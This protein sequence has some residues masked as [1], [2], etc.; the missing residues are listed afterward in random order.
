[1]RIIDLQMVGAD[2]TWRLEWTT[3]PG[4][5]YQV[6]RSS[7][8]YLP[9]RGSDWLPLTTIRAAGAITGANDLVGAT[10]DQRYYRVVELAPSAIDTQP[11]TI[12]YGGVEPAALP[13]GA[14][15]LRVRFQATDN[16]G[17][18][19]V[20]VRE[21]G[22]VL[23]HATPVGG[24]DWVLIVPARVTSFASRLF[25]ATATDPSG[26]TADSNT[27]G[28]ILA[29]P[30]YFIP[31]ETNGVP[32]EGRF[33]SVIETNRV[34]P[35]VF[36]PG[37]RPRA[38]EAPDLF[39]RFPEGGTIETNGPAS[40]IHFQRVSA[41]FEPGS[42]FRLASALERND[43][44]DKTLRVGAFG[45]SDLAALFQVSATNGVGLVLFD[46]FPI[47][48][49]GGTID[50]RGWVGAQF[51]SEIP[52]LPLSG[53]S[54]ALPGMLTEFARERTLRIP[55]SG[56]IPLGGAISGA[57]KMQVNA[58][59]PLWLSLRADGQASLAG[60]V[61]L[62][63]PNGQN[64]QA[65]LRLDDPNYCLALAASGLR[66]QAA[67]NLVDLLPGN[68]G[69]C[70]PANATA[71]QLA[72]A[73]SCLNSF[74]RAYAN[75]TA[76]VASSASNAP[77]SAAEPPSGVNAFSSALEAWGFSAL[78]G[79]IQ[80]LPL[81]AIV[82][83]ANQS[84]NQAGSA[85]ELPEVL[86]NRLALMRARAA[87]QAGGLNGSAAARAQLDQAL[88]QAE[89]AAIDRAQNP[90]A[91]LSLASMKQAA[92]LLVETEAA[93]QLAGL[94]PGGLLAALPNLFVRF[95]DQLADRFGVRTN[96]FTSVANPAINTMN[97]FIAIELLRDIIDVQ[98]SAQL[99]GVN[100][101][102]TRLDELTAQLGLRLLE[103]VNQ[104]LN[105]AEA[106]ADFP[107]FMLAAQDLM[108]L[109]SW[110]QLG[111]FPSVPELNALGSLS[112][113]NA[114]ASRINNLGQFELERPL[115]DKT[116]GRQAQEIRALLK[117]MRQ[118][119]SSV[120]FGAPP[121]RRACDQL[122]TQLT[123]IVNAAGLASFTNTL[124]LLELLEAGLL[125][126][127]LGARFS[128]PQPVSWE[129]TRLPLI[130]ARISQ[131][132]T[133]QLAWRELD[134]AIRL[135][136]AAADR[137]GTS[138]DQ[139]LRRAYLLQTASVITTTRTVAQNLLRGASGSVRLL[140]MAMPGDL[141]IDNPAGYACYN[142]LS[143][144]FFG[145]VRG[146]LRIP[147]M[148][149]SLTVPNASFDNRGGFDLTAFGLVNFN[150]G[151]F[152][153]PARQP[154]HIWNRQERGLAMEGGARLSLSNGMRFDASVSL[155]DPRYSFALSARGLE[156]DLGRQLILQR[157]TL[158]AAALNN[159]GASTR[160]ALADYLRELN[161]G[162]ET[163][164]NAAVGFPPI[165]ESG[166]GKPPEFSSPEIPFDF[167]TLNAW[168]AGI[169]A[170]TRAGLSNVAQS[171]N[172]VLAS[173]QRLN[174][175]AR[176]ATNAL[177]D[178][179]GKLA[180]LARRMEL[181]RKMKEASNLAAQQ[182]LA[183]GP[184]LGQLDAA[185]L[186]GARQELTN[187]LVLLT[188]D[189][190]NRLADSLDLV[191]IMYGTESTL[192]SLNA[193]TGSDLPL[194][195]D[196]CTN[197][198][199]GTASLFQRAEALALCT[200]RRQ[201]LNFGLNPTTGSVADTNRFQSFS[202]QE[203]DQATALMLR[204]E[205]V[206][207]TQGGDD[208]GAMLDLVAPLIARQRTLQLLEL[209]NNPSITP[210]RSIE[211]QMLLLNNAAAL[212]SA[213]IDDDGFSDLVSA[214]ESNLATLLSNTPPA[215][216]DRAK[217]EASLAIARRNRQI[218]SD[219]DHALGTD[220]RV[221]V[222]GSD[223]DYQPDFLT[224]LNHFFLVAQRPVPDSIKNNMDAY[225]RFKAQELRARPFTPDFL[226]NRL[227]EIKGLA[228][229]V[230]GLTDWAGFRMTN[231]FA[232]LTN[233]QLNLSNFTFSV[234]QVA[235]AQKAWWIL[236]RYEN[237]L[238]IHT[239]IYGSNLVASLNGSLAQAQSA[240]IAAA[241]RI[242]D[243]LVSLV[244]AI[245]FEDVIVPL[246]GG[247][248]IERISG[249]LRFNRQ[250]GFLEG[251]FGG[252]VRFSDVNTNLFFEI[253]EACLANT[254]A[255]S[256]D[257]QMGTP[258]PFGQARLLAGL[259]IAGSPAG[260]A[261]FAGDGT[262]TLPN[263][264][265]GD[266]TF[267]VSLRYDQAQRRLG[268]DALGS[269]LDLRLAE[270]FVLFDAGVGFE[271]TTGAPQ[272]SF[273]VSGSAG[274]FAKQ[275][276]LPAVIS[277]ASFHLSV[278]NLTTA[279]S[280]NT[281]AFALSL[282]NGVI[283]LPDIFH[284]GIC[285]TN[286]G[287][288]ATG[289]QLALVAANPLTV[290]VE[291]STKASFS[292][293]LDFRNLGFN[294]PGLTNLGIEVCSTRLAFRSNALPLLQDF[295]AT[296]ALPLPG[297]TSIVDVTGVDWA[298]D[299]FPTAG[300]IALRNGLRLL[301]LGGFT[302]DFITNSSFGIERTG[303][304]TI[305]NLAGGIKGTFPAN[306]LADAQNNAAFSFGTAGTFHWETGQEPALSLDQV[307]FGG[308]LKLGGP[309][310]FTLTGVDA[311]GIPNLTDTNSLASIT[312][313]GLPNIL[314]LAT[315]A[316][317]EISVN[318]ALGAAEFI[319]FGLKDAKFVFDGV[320][321]STNP[322][323]RFQVTALGFRE[324]E[325]LKMLGQENLPLRITEGSVEFLNPG[326]PLNQL[327]NPTNLRFTISGE[328]NVAL[329][330]PDA[331]EPQ[332]PRLSGAVNRA[333]ITLPNG[334]AGAPQFSVNG[335]FL[336]LENLKIGDM[337][338]LSGGLAVGNLNSPSE[339]FF[340]G[341]VG[342]EYNGA[343]IKA[344]VAA[345]TTGL[346]GLCLA[347]NAGPAGI[348]LDG[349][350]LGG[351][352]LTGAEGG[353][354]FLNQFADPCDFQ[355]FLELSSDGRPPSP[356]SGALRAASFIGPRVSDLAVLSWAELHELQQLHEKRKS[357]ESTLGRQGLM[358]ALS[359][360]VP[361]PTGD[362][363]PA[364]INLLCQRHPS[365]AENPAP[366]NY[367]GE[368][369]QRVIFK[370][371]SLG[372]DTVDDILALAN[373]NLQGSA[374]VIAVNF[375]NGVRD[376]VNTLIPRPPS[377]LGT[378]QAI[379]NDFIDR[380]LDAMRGAIIT[381]VSTALSKVPAN[382]SRLEAIYK[383]AYAGVSCVDITIQLKG[384]FS[385]A[386]VS[387]ALSAVGG[388]VASTTGSAGITG[389]VN[390][391][392]VPVGTGEFFY[393]ITDTNGNPNPSFC[394]NMHVAL[395]PLQFG[396]MGIKLDCPSC[397]TG[398]IQ[399]MGTF[400]GGLSSDVFAESSLL[401]RHFV[402]NAA[403]I[404]FANADVRTLFGVGA[405][406]LAP[407]QQ[408]AV[409]TSL[410]NLPEI[411]RFLQSTPGAVNEFG[412]NA[413]NALGART[414]QLI[415]DLYN[416]VNPTFQ[417][418]GEVQPKIFGFS[419][420]GGNSLV[421]ARMFADKTNARGDLAFSPSYILGNLPFFILS[422][423]SINNI[424]PALDQAEM[425]FSFGLPILSADL[426]HLLS[427][428]PAAF[429][430]S[431]LD[432]MM[433]NSTLT[434]GYKL[435]PFGFKLADGQG[436]IIV[437]TL[438]H[439][440]LNPARGEFVQPTAPDRGAVLK[441][442]LDANQLS[443]ATWAGR[444]P[445]LAALFAAGSTEAR[446]AANRE[447]L[448]D[449]FP[450]GGFVGA[451]KV[452]FPRPL[453]DAPPLSD[454]GQLFAPFEPSQ[455]E[456]RLRLAERIFTNYVMGSRQI[457]D[458]A[459][460]VPFPNPP[461]AV[462]TAALGP[463]AFINA[464][465][466][467]D[468]DALIA[469]GGLDL[470]PV[471]QFFMLGNVDVQLIGLPLGRGELI[472]DPGLGLFRL[473]AGIPSDSWLHQFVQGSLTGEIR[474]AEYILKTNPGQLPPG[475]SASDLEPE[476]R[477]NIV[478]N[479][480]KQAFAPGT[481][482]AQ[483]QAAINDAITRITDT[484]PKASVSAQLNL[485]VPTNLT[486]FLKFKQG[487]G[488]FAFSP[489]FDP[490]YA[491]PGS[492]NPV[493]FPDPD[494]NNPGPYTLARR[495]GGMAAVG[496]FEFGFN[497]TDPNTNRHLIVSIPEMALGIAGSS[498]SN[499]F[500]A[501]NG[502]VRVDNVTLPSAFTFNN[503][504]TPPFQFRDGLMQFNS[505]P[506]INAD[507]LNIAGGMT[508][509]DLGPFL[510]VRPLPA[511]ANPA[512]LL[513]GNLRVTRTSIGSSMS[514]SINAAEATI[515]IL[516]NNLRGT[517]FGEEKEPGRFTP[518]TFSTV[519]GQAWAASMK[520]DGAVEIR[521]PLDPTGPVFFRAEALRVNNS[522]VP[523]LAQIDGVGL[524]RF[525]LR[526]TIPNGLQ[527]TLFPGT[528]QQSIY[529]TGDNSATCLFVSSD[530]RIY[531][532]S[533]TRTLDLN[534]LANVEGRIEFGFE[535][536]NR[537][538][539]ISR[540]VV[541]N[542]VT[543]L[544]H[545]VT[546]TLA[547]SNTN[548][549]GSQLQ[550]DASITDSSNFSIVPHRLILGPKQ[551]ANIQVRFTPRTAGT[552]RPQL[553]LSNNSAAPVLNVSMTGIVTTLPKMHVQLASIDFG[554][555]PLGETRGQ[556]VRISNLGDTALTVSNIVTT[557][558]RFTDNASFLTVPA[559]SF[560][561]I[562]VSFTPTVTTATN[563]LLTFNSNDPS[564]SSAQVSLLGSG[565]NRFWYRQ[566]HGFGFEHLFDIEAKTD[567]TLAALGHSGTFWQQPS[568][569]RIWNE[570]PLKG[571]PGLNSLVF[572]SATEGF[573]AA[574]EGRVFSTANGGSDW[575][576]RNEAVFKDATI[577][578]RGVAAIRPAIKTY[579]FAGEQAGSARIVA[580]SVSASFNASTI[581]GTARGLR[582]MAFAPDF[583]GIAVGDSRTILRT[584]DQ[585]KSWDVIAPPSSVPAQT[586]FRAVAAHPTDSNLFVIVGDG[587]VI[588]TT[589]NA[590][591]NWSVRDSRT[592]E[593]LCS[594]TRTTTEYFVAGNNGVVRRSTTG[595]S[596]TIDDAQT[597]ADFRGLA[598]LNLDVWG[599]S[600]DGDIFH[601][602]TTAIGGP[603]SVVNAQNFSDTVTA[604]G[605]RIFREVYV[606]NEGTTNMTAE[607]KTST[608]TEVTIFPSG[609][610]T[611]SPGC[612]ELFIV[613]IE[614]PKSGSSSAT[615]SIETSSEGKIDL[616]MKVNVDQKAFTPL[617]YLY[618]P[619]CLD[620]GTLVLGNSTEI[621]M[622]VVN[623]GL[624]NLTIRDLG[625]RN[626]DA[627]SVYNLSVKFTGPLP[628]SSKED[629][630]KTVDFSVT[631]RV[632]GPIRG[633]IE[634]RSDAA[635]GVAI[636]EFAGNVVSSPDVVIVDTFP[637]GVPVFVNSVLRTTPAAFTVVPG[638]PGAG[639]LQNGTPVTLTANASH[640][641]D[642]VPYAFQRWE[643][644][645]GRTLSFVA[646]RTP[647]KFLARYAP[648]VVAS[649]SPAAPAPFKAE[650]CSF[651]PPT[652][653]TF[654][655][656]VKISQARLTLPWLG[657]AQSSNFKV[658]GALFLSLTR[659]YG[660][661]DSSRIRVLVPTNAPAF[662][663]SEV[664]EITPSAWNF[665]LQEG[666]FRLNARSPGVQIF[667]TSALPPA[668]LDVEVNIRTN[669]ANRRAFARFSTLDELALAPGL[670][671]LGPGAA[672]LDLGLNPTN[673]SIRLT[674]NSSIRA[675][676][677]PNSSNWVINRPYNFDFNASA[678][679]GPV[680]FASRTLLADLAV[681][682]V[683]ALAGAQIGPSFN[684]TSFSL[685]AND[686]G[687]EF[688]RSNQIV[689]SSASFLA[690]GT[691][692]LEAALPDSGLTAG[693]VL[694]RQR[695][696]GKAV[697]TA[698]PFQGR[699]FVDIPPTFLNS[700]A[701]SR[702]WE[703]DLVEVPGFN[704]DS[705]NFTVRMPLPGISFSGF[706][707]NKNSVDEDNFLEFTRRP[708]ET[709]IKLRNEHDLV[710]GALKFS[711]SLSTGGSVSGEL[712]GRL[713]LEGPS[714]LDALTD[715]VSM[716][717]DRNRKPEFILNRHFLG[718]PYRLQLGLETP[719]G[720]ACLLDIFT[721]KPLSERSCL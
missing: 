8:A 648:G 321:N 415:L 466:S 79:P 549:L 175:D 598:A 169:I 494:P 312:L 173:V 632:L 661:L 374:E 666:F 514:V 291:S 527:F 159:F 135:L 405:G 212:Q 622:P 604:P 479:A 92:R 587:G 26:N 131:I 253:R 121:F 367:N 58:G 393:S 434:F 15:A 49:R 428:N 410:L 548:T 310:G 516:G 311:N 652:D 266:K 687:V 644:G 469:P 438:E 692:T 539:M 296:L 233:L 588:L 436:R 88:A 329:S 155:V 39:L 315:N 360:D 304:I 370:F 620:L 378:N 235:E 377:G 710:L 247:V 709:R 563:A 87:I 699:L 500:P 474:T 483:K 487:A 347:V 307:S 510:R 326:L 105:S 624:T 391:F 210:Q 532:D 154:L 327:F 263:S 128:F 294:L 43:A 441:A 230:I 163:I 116:M 719:S 138:N 136:V 196:P 663:G 583:T 416:A 457:G 301:D 716:D 168:S 143:E 221:Q 207:Q 30:D 575:T 118:M 100:L 120:T 254:G 636:V 251:C 613:A 126:R 206:V 349:G 179:I 639:Q 40:T 422:G 458:L 193:S 486:S 634:I 628:P 418:C 427:T 273:R 45:F 119:P 635:N 402:T 435:S 156:L 650:A 368:F 363:P 565:S 395:G 690:D 521:S 78:A 555:T 560:R 199:L 153:V 144:D 373:I 24:S 448:R 46:K 417:F 697:V 364:T 400:I 101:F 579:A 47:R 609:V 618:V 1:M 255:Y 146:R 517:I 340:A 658:N 211:L 570:K 647:G 191:R 607:V 177:G 22:V 523:F 585:G 309:S 16:V 525:E 341:M 124:P 595:S 611:V 497:L 615:V 463:E 140:D 238:R 41:G 426:L 540:G 332:L 608:A 678:T 172:P 286:Q 356:P 616:T 459:V 529:Q 672:A 185:L 18:S 73:T 408:I 130:T 465:A 192:Q 298:L 528:D 580:G 600:T 205:E 645:S 718:V 720:G 491:L 74:A 519:P 437:P 204:L 123:N 431:Q 257:G 637:R 676:A 134:Q 60:P 708:S 512:N 278:S 502:R 280:Y 653:V 553:I 320:N 272:G 490:G 305:V 633:Q 81:D 12:A 195:G 289:A 160:D 75:F 387:V 244:N 187:I 51:L 337:A 232:V 601:R 234:T 390:L 113:M 53:W 91:V 260:V 685:I 302:L 170:N 506:A 401:I 409:L 314:K 619:P 338:G 477:L 630:E 471:N 145:A 642:G 328:V 680:T 202:E 643:P 99:T 70:I 447:L 318:G 252:R 275:K 34:R 386:P 571:A 638:T 640:S 704:F 626:S 508:P 348:P 186:S 198:M 288:P 20:A 281:N 535:P 501:L 180:N 269:N 226:T 544:G 403:G 599:V 276:P 174:D 161:A 547:I 139:N 567:A 152:A 554:S 664:L 165:D 262:L 476:A 279:F 200:I 649:S 125:H 358:R 536:V 201:A 464:I 94:P 343:G 354:S 52:L 721:D 324:G 541:T 342:G 109:S 293:A 504:S 543:T 365:V 449:Y 285:P 526:L 104:A 282:S 14:T 218:K 249:R 181:R 11:P 701:S 97:R 686:I 54:D 627:S 102:S 713:G 530:G 258:L 214:L 507:F 452:Q 668:A 703:D 67:S 228:S 584:A 691:F 496:S 656:W 478:S 702:L 248:D 246:P 489:R 376:F 562:L 556:P 259:A 359:A 317:F 413:I 69:A 706:K 178:E 115:G 423:G 406:K 651:K 32:R 382:G 68:P 681:V 467:A 430:G 419:L 404:Q 274:M 38:G 505:A 675:L 389:S 654:G 57:P 542:F 379:I 498:A 127:E 592:T 670:L 561:D 366:A 93:R 5:D 76:L 484:L 665:D 660:S 617:G 597:T 369:A 475:T 284:N 265:S 683:F 456:A 420:T 245:E 566:R 451:A 167:S 375:G 569:K 586:A 372:R 236:G 77:P 576:Q 412:Q 95:A 659:T 674:L 460:Y 162:L 473:S 222:A 557:S 98:A 411:Q 215:A 714:P 573:A 582:G 480:L 485:Q 336:N 66:I 481:T 297:Q 558:A 682:R 564:A 59:H 443:R 610:K 103:N 148:G 277:P 559:G 468:V 48:W 472:A 112:F 693:P 594:I 577:N 641:S 614:T 224:Q 673:P 13:S 37:G 313:T 432:H 25:S 450:H 717:F 270:D 346:I 612:Q 568:N 137:A 550:V 325:K 132:A 470:Y 424:V 17:V 388:A 688:L 316:P 462:F 268:F 371:T 522:P 19:S 655:P 55:L 695:S 28:V 243:A 4:L 667:D 444:G 572:I 621:S 429:A 303:S 157:P 482:A 623:L 669:Q 537:A 533:G 184:E 520:L 350:T 593:A 62:S 698:N 679:I 590:G 110:A 44:T 524:E 308:R 546:Q 707:M 677:I 10:V 9:A 225:V 80:A 545:S 353:V 23:G 589:A 264:P 158:S 142:R 605:E 384:T 629:K 551:T 290:L 242:A 239:A 64:V 72:Q 194:P 150:G 440:P 56:E 509:I 495:N 684:G 711:F 333:V 166:F 299:G 383:A 111:M 392:G 108:E 149:L 513:G 176:A 219:V 292:G 671:A 531:F 625:V 345:R 394:G 36:R 231:D 414:F 213:G 89:A 453:T 454:L 35:F 182:Q 322:E 339:L 499:I 646:G 171:L 197:Y 445:D 86:A 602:R 385:Y 133:N 42:P 538:P 33:L 344:I 581:R 492:T 31:L 295:N 84:G 21:G 240:S 306:L 83:L 90:N 446:N 398:T 190:P 335:F 189:L 397:V 220:R 65:D 705:E 696:S 407:E 261:T 271:L 694:L 96:V 578:W 3:T 715:R 85:P 223:A 208:Q 574:E 334:F 631:P 27:G 209:T 503:S 362:C 188:P 122:E 534:G 361:C 267:S 488:F 603:L 63:W 515:P 256:I 421:S 237:A 330:P 455:V 82:D 129:S 396:Q 241:N 606:A 352:L 461:T 107:A 518:F 331:K 147:K 287:Q 117:V 2:N 700:T 250:T 50:D 29:N 203:L 596:W 6:Q 300:S 442:A 712:F 351:I 7:N 151:Q 657:D 357:L 689:K 217:S 141:F 552:F 106:A 319:F 183:G 216:F 61:R 511:N 114:L 399:A 591:I 283:R 433:A 229:L 439:H 227:G 425:G 355:S 381:S 662:R 71:A 380:S 323:P 493:I 164:A